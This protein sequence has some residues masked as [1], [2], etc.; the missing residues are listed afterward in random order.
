MNNGFDEIATAPTLTLEPFAAQEQ[1]PIIE[2]EEKPE[3]DESVLTAEERQVVAQFAQQ[4]DL[5]NSQMILQYGAGTQKKMADFSEKALDNVRTKDLGEIGD[6]LTDVVKELK[7]FGQEEE[8]G[9]LGIF[10]KSTN[11]L[12]VLKAKYAKR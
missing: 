12:Q 4:I 10:K 7:E 1:C 3:L 6:L 11:K 2:K 5:T 8:K 9:F